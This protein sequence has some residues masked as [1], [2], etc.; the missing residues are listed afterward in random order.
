MRPSNMVTQWGFTLLTLTTLALMHPAKAQEASAPKHPLA[1]P[2]A[3][4]DPNTQL[5]PRYRSIPANPLPAPWADRLSVSRTRS[6]AIAH[7]LRDGRNHLRAAMNGLIGERASGAMSVAGKPGAAF[8]Q[9]AEEQ[10]GIGIERVIGRDDR[11]RVSNTARYPASTHCAL[12]IHFPR[13]GWVRGSGEMVGPSSILTSGHS[14]F[15]FFTWEWA[16]FMEVVPGLNGTRKP[17][18]SA[19]AVR[20]NTFINWVLFRDFNVDMAV[21]NLDRPIGFSTGTLGYGAFIIGIWPFQAPSF[22][23]L[24]AYAADKGDGLRQWRTEGW[25]WHDSIAT[26]QLRYWLDTSYGT[27][28]AG[29]YLTFGGGNFI[30]GINSWETSSLNGATHITPWKVGWLRF[31]IR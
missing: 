25:I 23:R 15:N 29:V 10:E 3:E 28:G 8:T 20:F 22:A 24:A 5:N 7:D 14:V 16:D 11:R 19:F 17:F 30:T 9:V 2:L 13:A 12:F 1:A 27:S 18:G 6:G 21:V 4:N 31:W 26:E